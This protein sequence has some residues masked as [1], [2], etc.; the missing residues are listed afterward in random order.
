MNS[1]SHHNIFCNNG[2]LF[3]LS[4]EAPTF[5][6][7]TDGSVGSVYLNQFD[8]NTGALVLSQA[9]SNFPFDINTVEFCINP[10]SEC[11]EF[12]V[13]SDTLE[14]T[15]FELDVDFDDTN[16]IDPSSLTG[17]C[18][19]SFVPALN[20]NR[21]EPI[22]CQIPTYKWESS[23]APS[24]P[25]T[26]IPGA[27]LE[28]FTTSVTSST[29]YYRR[30]VCNPCTEATESISNVAQVDGSANIAPTADAGGLFYTCPN[31]DIQI[32]GNPVSYTHLTLPT[33]YSV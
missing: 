19:G 8:E 18:V 7:T 27:F 14:L 26:I 1:S 2:K 33:I 16:I 5:W 28:D 22:A 4:N 6:E 10:N 25:W 30:L 3:T 24:G 9:I 32:G 12:Y 20:G 17:F 11:S 31:T 29:M 15:H 23:S 21:V 13:V